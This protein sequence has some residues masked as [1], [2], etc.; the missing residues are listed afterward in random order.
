MKDAPWTP[1]TVDLMMKLV[2]E[3]RSM[4]EIGIALGRTRNAIIGKVQRERIIRGH[5]PIPRKRKLI[6]E[7]ISE[8]KPEFY[9]ELLYNTTPKR[10]LTRHQQLPRV[11]TRGIGFVMPALTPPPPRTGPAVGILDVT[12]CQW[13]TGYD[14]AIAGRHTFCDAPKDGKGPYCPFHDAL[15]V[16][17]PV[18]VEARKRTIIPTTQL[19][20]MG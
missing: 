9:K 18:P 4:G 13:P 6:L 19:R 3:G 1:E 10:P 7:R 8:G 12:G 17:K 14:E 16:A 15:K 2:T 11:S 20:M 5:V